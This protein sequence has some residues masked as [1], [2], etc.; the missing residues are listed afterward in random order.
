M[1][2]GAYS[3][4]IMDCIAFCHKTRGNR[5]CSIICRKD[6][7]II[8]YY[9]FVEKNFLKQQNSSGLSTLLLAFR[10]VV[11]LVAI[12]SLFFWLFASVFEI[13]PPTGQIYSNWTSDGT[14]KAVFSWLGLY[15][16]TQDVNYVSV[17]VPN[18]SELQVVEPLH[19]HLYGPIP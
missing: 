19:Q 13:I 16:E 17:P 6:T 1:C 4:P 15:F 5:I 12:V 7:F 9:Y 14:P 11:V 8:I 18:F 3:F 2:N 10:D